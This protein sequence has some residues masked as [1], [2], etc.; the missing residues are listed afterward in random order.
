M[1]AIDGWMKDEQRDGWMDYGNCM[2]IHS[3]LI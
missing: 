2:S 1:A 3:S